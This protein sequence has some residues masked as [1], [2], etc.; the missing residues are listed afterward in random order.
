ME[1]LLSNVDEE[2]YDI[3]WIKE[4]VDHRKKDSALSASEGFVTSGTSQKP[5]IT[6]KGW[7]FQVRWKDGSMD[8][9]PLSQVKEALP[10][11]VAEYVVAQKI[12]RE[13]AFNWW[14]MKTLRKRERI[15]NKVKARKARKPNTKFGIEIPSTVEEAKE[16]DQKNG[17]SYWKD[18]IKKEYD[19]IKVAFRLLENDDKPPPVYTEILCLLIFEVKFDLR[20]KA[21]YV[22]GGHLTEPPSTIMY[23]SVVSRESI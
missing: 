17:N 14:V 21:R 2:R 5:V 10:V 11:E 3:G 13:P 22:A 4:I 9:L 20:R 18:T 6:T 12:H 16:L 23:S 8:W 19:N 1:S 7:D 15:I